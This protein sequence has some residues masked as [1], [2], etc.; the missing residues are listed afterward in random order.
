MYDFPEGTSDTWP[1][2]PSAKDIAPA[3]ARRAAPVYSQQ[4]HVT[5]ERLKHLNWTLRASKRR[6]LLKDLQYR[7]GVDALYLP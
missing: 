6:D 7:P 5:H 4:E 3:L 2:A 1:P